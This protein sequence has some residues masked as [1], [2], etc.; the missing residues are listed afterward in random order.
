[1]DQAVKLSLT[2]D[3]PFPLD[4]I[5]RRDGETQITRILAEP[6]VSHSW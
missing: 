1:L 5:E 3:P 2:V 4:I 6:V